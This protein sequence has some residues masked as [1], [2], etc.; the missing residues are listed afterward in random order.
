MTAMSIVMRQTRHALHA[1]DPTASEALRG[2]FL[3][4]MGNRRTVD[5]CRE[6]QLP[7]GPIAK[8]LGGCSVLRDDRQNLIR[9]L[10]APATLSPKPT[11]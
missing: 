6:H 5:V 2:P 1:G 7:C 11:T 8:W 4:W 9:A 3:Q 10:I